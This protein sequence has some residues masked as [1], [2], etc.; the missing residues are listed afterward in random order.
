M[1]T[2]GKMLCSDDLKDRSGLQLHSILFAFRAL[3]AKA[4]NLNTFSPPLLS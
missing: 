2:L 3:N 1:Q 4:L